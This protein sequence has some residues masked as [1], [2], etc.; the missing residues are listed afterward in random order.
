MGRNSDTLLAFLVGAV[1]GGV[2]ALLLAPEKGEVTRARIR[3][4]SG[5][6]YS[7]G[8]DRVGRTVQDVEERAHEYGEAARV[9]AQEVANA[10][11]EKAGSVAG[12]ARHQ[13]DAV[14]EAVSEAK[15]A[16]KRELNKG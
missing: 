4:K 16:Y 11:R 9:K 10:A 8:R 5:D 2:A 1:A 6:L 3:E 7:S 12:T 13:V 14:K 15:D